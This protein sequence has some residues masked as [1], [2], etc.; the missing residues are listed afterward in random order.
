MSA[1][2][3]GVSTDVSVHVTRSAIIPGSLSIPGNFSGWN[4]V[5]PIGGAIGESG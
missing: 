2:T 3:Y 4:L 5:V 1:N